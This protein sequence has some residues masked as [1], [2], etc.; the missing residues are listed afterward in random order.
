VLERL[1][2]RA[3]QLPVIVNTAIVP[4]PWCRSAAG[5]LA[6]SIDPFDAAGV[7]V[8]RGLAVWLV[9]PVELEPVELPEVPAAVEPLDPEPLRVVE[10][11]GG[12]ELLT[13]GAVSGLPVAGVAPVG[14]VEAVP[15]VDVELGVPVA[16]VAPEVPVGVAA[17]VPGAEGEVEAG[18]G[19]P[20]EPD[21]AGLVDPLAPPMIG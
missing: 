11:V 2:V 20:L 12:G 16:G 19:A 10:P 1:Q 15:G 13:C 14:L 4:C 3:G 21:A 18:P 9:V 5:S 8:V 17:A 6:G 7:T